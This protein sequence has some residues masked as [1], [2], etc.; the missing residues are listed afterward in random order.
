MLWTEDTTIWATRGGCPL[1][2]SPCLQFE[3]EDF[4]IME[5][6]RFLFSL[7]SSVLP[8]TT[9]PLLGQQRGTNEERVLPFVLF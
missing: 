4:S 8:R 6:G 1:V 9:L 5:S 2:V 3:V 7:K